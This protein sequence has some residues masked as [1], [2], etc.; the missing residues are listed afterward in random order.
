VLVEDQE[1]RSSHRDGG[2]WQMDLVWHTSTWT[3]FKD[4]Y[5]FFNKGG[6]PDHLY[7]IVSI[8]VHL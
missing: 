8:N 3:I 5:I 1:G 4:I 6:H 2:R 7:Q